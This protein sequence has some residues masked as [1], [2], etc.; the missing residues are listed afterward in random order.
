MPQHPPPDQ[1]LRLK[2]A[3]AQ[4]IGVAVDQLQVTEEQLA[5]VHMVANTSRDLLLTTPTGSGKTIAYMA[6]T[7]L[8]T[9]TGTTVVIL[10]LRALQEDA[11]DRAARLGNGSVAWSGRA[12]DSFPPIVIVSTEKAISSSFLHYLSSLKAQRKLFRIVYDEVHLLLTSGY[13]LGMRNVLTM[14]GRY[15]PHLYLSA[16][17]PPTLERA[18]RKELGDSQFVTIRAPAHRRNLA[19]VIDD[20]PTWS[21]MEESLVALVESKLGTYTA[22][23]K[24]VIFA[25]T[26]KMA[27]E[28]HALL[29]PVDPSIGLF[30]GESSPE[31]KS[32]LLQ[33]FKAGNTRIVVCTSG[34]GVGIDVKGIE[35]VVIY[36]LTYD[37]LTFCPAERPWRER[38]WCARHSHHHH[39]R[40]LPCGMGEGRRPQVSAS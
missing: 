11:V 7:N 40:G 38:P 15:G 39:L 32:R 23:S 3:I 37:L 2:V 28:L 21:D 31:E 20:R 30:T 34:F 6:P 4:T 5:A 35:D 25:M 17:M 12:P 33:S 1:V 27:G 26:V 10:P 14:T 19:Y 8:S 18:L 24:M 36:G 9:Y 16:T 22:E 29:Q 13:R